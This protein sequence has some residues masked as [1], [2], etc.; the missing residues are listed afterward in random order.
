MITSF[1]IKG[2]NNNLSLIGII[3]AMVGISGIIGFAGYR[4]Y[5]VRQEKEAHKAFAQAMDEFDKTQSWPES[6]YAFAH[7][8]KQHSSSNLYPFFLFYQ[9]EA[10]NKQGDYDQ[11]L[12][13]MESALQALSEKSPLYGLY[14]I[15]HALMQ[16]E[17]PDN[18]IQEKGK[19]ILQ[20]LSVNN[21]SDVQPLALYYLGYFAYIKNDIQRAQDYWSKLVS[22]GNAQDPLIK[23]AEQYMPGLKL[24]LK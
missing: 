14:A 17:S 15:K 2:N 10:L 7:G 9:A 16:L 24:Q 12:N 13:L 3:I 18:V 8:A 19:Q 21:S 20:K 4:W 5:T 23:M 22:L 11:A 6:A 1:N